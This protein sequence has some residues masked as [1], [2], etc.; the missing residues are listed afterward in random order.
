LIFRGQWPSESLSLSRA[1]SLTLSPAVYMPNA[2]AA[3]IMIS[4]TMSDTTRAESTREA[5]V[6]AGTH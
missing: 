5:E 3:I 6:C 1:L 2:A 4:G